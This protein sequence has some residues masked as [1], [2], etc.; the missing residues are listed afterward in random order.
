MKYW[1]NLPDKRESLD[2]ILAVIDFSS[3][4]FPVFLSSTVTCVLT[5]DAVLRASQG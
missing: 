3:N 4:R 1:K 5:R 2:E